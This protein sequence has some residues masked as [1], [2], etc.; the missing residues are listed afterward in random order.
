M[1]E[2]FDDIISEKID[3]IIHQCFLENIIDAN[4]YATLFSEIFLL[5]I[6]NEIAEE[7]Y[8]LNY[9]IHEI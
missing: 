5:I 7:L 3:K 9:I 6:E 8:F 4:A 2:T 1:K